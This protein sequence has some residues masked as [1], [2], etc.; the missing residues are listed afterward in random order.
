MTTVAGGNL[1]SPASQQNEE[2][3]KCSL[4]LITIIIHTNIPFTNM[5]QT[6]SDSS[7][8]GMCNVLALNSKHTQTYQVHPNRLAPLTPV[9]THH[10][11]P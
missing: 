7:K 9:T 4:M 10:L 6:Q 5:T 1:L 2:D 8:M 3:D 11:D